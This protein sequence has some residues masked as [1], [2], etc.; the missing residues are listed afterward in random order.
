[1]DIVK[2]S[3]AS[4][5]KRRIQAARVEFSSLN[6]VSDTPCH[7]RRRSRP[8]RPNF[9]HRPLHGEDIVEAGQ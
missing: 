4:I 6:Y 5:A 2:C 1:V 9:L 7:F 8:I 3:P